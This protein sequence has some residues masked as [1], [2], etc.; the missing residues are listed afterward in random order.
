M[1]HQRSRTRRAW[2][3]FVVVAIACGTV[4]STAGTAVAQSASAPGVNSAE[5]LKNPDCDATRKQIKFPALTAPACVVEW[6]DGADNGGATAQGVT[7][8][9]IKVVVLY[10]DVKQDSR[11]PVG[12][13]LNQSTGEF[14]NQR[15]PIVDADAVF[16]HV[17]E[18]WGRKVEYTFV[19]ASGADETAQRADAVEVAALKPFAVLDAAITGG[20]QSMGG[21]V[22]ETDLIAKGVPVVLTT[23]G[24]VPQTLNE[25]SRGVAKNVAEFAGKSLVGKK[26]QYGGDDV[27]GK[28]RT[29]GVLYQSGDSGFNV[30]TLK[31]EFAKYGGKITSEAAFSVPPGTA[32]ADAVTLATQQMPTLIAKLKNDGVTTIINVLDARNGLG[33]AMNAAETAEYT[34]EWYFGSG[35]SAG[36][37]FPGDLDIIVRPF[38]AN[39][40][41]HAFGAT[42]VLPFVANPTNVNPVQWYWGTD[43]GSLWAPAQ[44]LLGAL[45]TRIHLAGP[46]LTKA[47][48]AP[49]ALE[50]YTKAGGAF[51]NSVLTTASAP[52][53]KDGIVTVDGTLT[54]F[55]PERT[56]TDQITKVSGKG[57]WV[58]LDGGK[59]Y[60]ANKWPKNKT[61]FFDTKL[62]TS[63]AEYVDP[64]A[65]EP[66]VPSFPC[67]DCPST[68]A[69]TPTPSNAS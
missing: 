68:G 67:T 20:N 25:T 13:Y 17:Y 36:G 43:K 42:W 46:K 39:Q 60:V 58:Y 21:L 51:S 65:T 59:R 15:D 37:A 26:A 52:L 62:T 33:A 18:T 34:P 4:A 14:S 24:T 66:K 12:L 19:L 32:Q 49:G 45:Y 55:D 2:L 23:G 47:K 35:G 50:G 48:M 27:S 22:F 3:L 54:W 10:T 29:F 7:K 38:P 30:D 9:A 6:K 69:T 53:G 61:G 5:A 11:N 44:G 57:A 31:S 40:T 8:D 28:P 1:R 63:V 56:A 41:K 16:A 64:P